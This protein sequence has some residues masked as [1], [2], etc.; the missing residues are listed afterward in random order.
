MLNLF[1]KGIT[2]ATLTVMLSYLNSNLTASLAT[3]DLR[4]LLSSDSAIAQVLTGQFVSTSSQDTLII[5]GSRVGAVTSKTTRKDLVKLFGAS[6]LKDGSI[7]GAEGIG[8]FSV[9]RVNLGAEKSFTVVWSNNAKTKPVSVTDLGTAWKTPEGIG[10]GTSLTQ[11]RQKLGEFKLFG[12]GWDY[13]G[14][15]LLEKTKL[16]RYHRK[17]MIQVEAAPNAANK[18]PKDYRVVSGDHELYSNNPH[19]KPLGIRV[20]E[21]SVVLNSS[22]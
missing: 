10:V 13:S 3:F 11:L 4:Q 5:P 6:R 16:S 17:L 8:K 2:T 14:T 1:V 9:T 20:G 21:I 22:K 7:Y 18:F 15:V 19:W 12:L